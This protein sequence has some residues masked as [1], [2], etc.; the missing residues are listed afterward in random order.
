MGSSRK[1]DFDRQES[2]SAR[3]SLILG[4]QNDGSITVTFTD[5]DLEA[6]G[7]FTPPI[8]GGA[9]IT[10]DYI[11]TLLE[12]MNIVYGVRWDTIQES[13]FQCN[14]SRRPVKAV[15]IAQG[16]KPVNEVAEYFE[17]NPYLN[18]PK[19]PEDNARVDYRSYS[20][21][22]IVKQEQV[23]A[24][25]RPRKIGQDGKNVHG[26][27]LPHSMIRPEGVRGGQNT[28]SNG[29][30]IT[31]AIN[32][33]LIQN[34]NELSVQDNLVI[35][36][37]VGYAT[38]NIIF[39]GDVLIEG[40]VSDGFKIYSGGSVTIKQ[41]FDVTDVITRTDLSVAGGI[42]GRGRALVKVGGTLKTKFIENCRVACRRSIIV[43]TEIINS[44]VY[45]MER[46]EMGDKGL[47]L[48][49]EIYAIHGVRTGGIGKKA[50]KA[51]HIHCGVDFTVQQ[52]KEKNNDQ[53]RIIA[54]KLG[55][56]RELMAAPGQDG[57]KQAK[58][59]ELRRRLEDE[60]KKTGSRISGL[61]GRLNADENAAVEVSGEIALGTLIEI[62]Q[63]AFFVSEPL[64]KV[65]IRLD[66]SMG[67]LICEP[68]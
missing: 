44:S 10:P 1:N 63:I 11:N 14:T 51:T 31:A 58:M 2:P 15:L 57:E 5:Q 50:G 17:L 12:K 9:L 21:F 56:L 25:L 37:P 67:K 68:L 49:G 60:Q 32:G 41:T 35:K 39:P 48:G 3:S 36:G 16:D 64:R 6:W 7:D 34:N 59:E 46:I 62:C 47:I 45:T 55:K 8:G 24:R 4:G 20:P 61:L 65:R 28:K 43:D 13:A 40:P 30:Y 33:Q 19:I 29:K 52:E 38:G 42:I 18:A 66:K 26:I 22:T 23:L 27:T 54:A 53:L